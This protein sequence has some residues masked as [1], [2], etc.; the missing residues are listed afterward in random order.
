MRNISD[1]IY[2]ENR[3][4]HFIFNC[5]FSENLAIYQ[6]MWKNIVEPG[7]RHMKIWRMRL[8]R[9]IPM[10][11]KTLSQYV[12]LIAFPVQQWLHKRTS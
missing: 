12:A 2:R 10:A 11:T 9:W 1:D 5:L 7:T 6:T 4:T 8:A 3:K